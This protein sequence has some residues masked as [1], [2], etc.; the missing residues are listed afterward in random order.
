MSADIILDDLAFP[1]S[2]DVH[3]NNQIEY[4]VNK[5]DLDRSIRQNREIIKRI[6]NNKKYEKIL[7]KV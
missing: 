1:V 4:D 3:R 5:E 7:Q 2:I 6:R